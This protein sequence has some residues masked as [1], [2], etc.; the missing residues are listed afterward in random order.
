MG[1]QSLL[2]VL[3]TQHDDTVS[4]TPSWCQQV[5]VTILSNVP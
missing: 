4:K 1:V 2:A 3:I 5:S